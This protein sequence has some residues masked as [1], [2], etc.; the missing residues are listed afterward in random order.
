MESSYSN[1]ITVENT[2]DAAYS[3]LTIEFNKWWTADCGQVE[4]IGDEITFKFGDTRW[5]M[6]DKR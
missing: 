4:V 3:A 1:E 5:V 6:R 2:P